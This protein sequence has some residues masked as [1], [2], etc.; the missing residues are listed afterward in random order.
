M[1]HDLPCRRTVLYGAAAGAAGLTLTACGD[2]DKK[3]SAVPTAAVDLGSADAVPVGGAKLYRNDRLVVAQPSSGDYRAFS[4][5]CTHEG[6]VVSKLEGNVVTCGCHG[7]RFNATDG[8]VE[9]GPAVKPLPSVPV[10]VRAGRLV[11]GPEGKSGDDDDLDGSVG[12][13]KKKKSTSGGSSRKRSG[14]GSR[15]H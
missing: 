1:P 11:A 7:S 12:G 8:A 10:R 15:K 2:D 13:T 5:V 6:C 3:A 4:A 9:Q 14:S